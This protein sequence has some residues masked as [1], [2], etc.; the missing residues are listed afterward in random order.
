M[1]RKKSCQWREDGETE[2]EDAPSRSA[3]KRQSLALQKLGE[4]LS[5][6]APAELRDLDLSPE[7]AEALAMHARIR[8]HEGRRRQMQ[9]IGRLMRETDAEP[10]RA[11]L[12]ARREAASADTAR[13]HL[14]EQWRETLLNAPDADM[15]NRLRH[16]LE[17]ASAPRDG[18]NAADSPAA[19]ELRRLVR[20]AR[21]ARA[22]GVA[23][24]HASRALFRALTR[25]LAGHPGNA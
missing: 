10:L 19:E 7:L 8:D 14:A 11:A 25:A 16:F 18:R 9:Y 21:A 4:E 5:R 2:R 3:K 15:E 12:A 24:P 20:E 13:F 17:S 1:P 22:N 6:L 23:A